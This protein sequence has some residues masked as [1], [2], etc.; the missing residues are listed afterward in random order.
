MTIPEDRNRFH[1]DIFS[2][3]TE[4]QGERKNPGALRPRIVDFRGPAINGRE[5]FPFRSASVKARIEIG[6]PVG[7]CFESAGARE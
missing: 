5:M 6:Y 2:A 4:R 3:K 7:V 1:P